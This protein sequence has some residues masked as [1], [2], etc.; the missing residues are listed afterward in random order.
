MIPFE[1][2]KAIVL[3]NTANFG[4]IKVDLDTAVGHYLAETVHTDR[5]FPPFNRVTKDG[6]AIAFEAYESG[7]REFKLTGIA[8]AGTPELELNDKLHAI[9]VMTGAMLP[10]GT[11]TVIMYEQLNIQDGTAIIEKPVKQGQN[12]HK[13]GSDEPQGSVVLEKGL[14]ISPAEIGVLA[15]VGKK[16]VAVYRKPKVAIIATGNELVAIETTP[17]P[18]Q[19]RTSNAYSIAAALEELGVSW[20]RF[21]L[22]DQP[23]ELKSAL[24]NLSIKFDV[25]VLSGGVSKG[26]YDY[27]PEILEAIGTS[28]LFH[29][30]QQ[31]PGKP[32]WFGKNKKENTTI[33]AFPGNPVSTFANFHIY[34]VPWL[35]KCLHQEPELHKIQ[36]VDAFNN[37]LPLTRFVRSYASLTK[38]GLEAKLILGNGS[39]DLT[40]LCKANGFVELA[41]DCLHKIGDWVPFIPTKRII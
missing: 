35:Y 17:K 20:E 36:L 15:S 9:E 16:Q 11:D 26:K 2:A 22:K 34:F 3:D 31:R 7:Q 40:S 6:I 24:E 12:I 18:H 41:P 8:A 30:V 10:L 25:L 19:I 38:N 14:R 32:F 33:F 21:H 29:R 37:D 39:V 23:E 4:T 28:K 5:D 13:Q 27:I 1:E